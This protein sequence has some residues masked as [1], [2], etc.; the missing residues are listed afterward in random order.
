M[1]TW[2]ISWRLLQLET[3]GLR[4]CEECSF[5]RV[6]RMQIANYWSPW[7]PADAV[8]TLAYGG[9]YQVLAEPGLRI[10]SVN[11][12]YCD[13]LNTWSVF[14]FDKN[15]DIANQFGWL[16]ATLTAARSRGERVFLLGHIAPG[17]ADNFVDYTPNFFP[18]CNEQFR[19][20]YDH[21]SDVIV[22]SFYAHEHSDTFRV[23]L[24]QSSLPVASM[25]L[26]PSITPFQGMNPAVRLYQYSHDE[27]TVQNYQQY[28]TNVSRDNVVGSILWSVEYDFLATYNLPDMT[29]ESLHKLWLSFHEPGS[30]TWLAFLEH[31]G[32]G[33]EIPAPSCEGNCKKQR[34]C[35]IANTDYDTF[36]KCVVAKQ[37][38]NASRRV[39]QR[40]QQF[41]NDV[42]LNT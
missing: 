37:F 34:L 14:D 6:T 10:V 12:L 19:N 27:K 26:A 4:R 32:H 18:Y 15:K 7:L 22:N 21:F 31:F 9:Y 38:T 25:F 28:T 41:P 20:L 35:A 16:N 24:D 36:V 17:T 3:S 13:I 39:D 8:Q 23:V 30:T 5:K 1:R 29:P 2:R 40:R 42:R 33:T 11:T